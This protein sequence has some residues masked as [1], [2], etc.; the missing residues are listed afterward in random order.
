MGKRLKVD[1]GAVSPSATRFKFV[2][3][4]GHST[5][6]I[7]KGR[8]YKLRRAD[9]GKRITVRVTY[10]RS[11]VETLKVEDLTQREG[12]GTD[13]R[14]RASLARMHDHDEAAHFTWEA[15]HFTQEFW[16]ERY[17]GTDRV[18]SGNPN[19]R[20]VEHASDLTPGAALDVGCGE[21]ADVVWLAGRGW[22]VTGVDVS[23]VAL[24]RAAQ[25]AEERGVAERTSFAQVDLVA[26]DALPGDF[27][28]VSAQFMHLPTSVFERVY[29]AIAR[30]VRPGGALLVVGHHPADAATGLRNERLSHLLF[31]PEQ[32]T[33]VL[34]DAE[35]DF[36][37]P[38]ADPRPPDRTT[39]P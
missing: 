1:L 24:D 14:C 5:I 17:A 36:G 19:P 32:V 27:D 23:Q 35:W 18:W 31:T 12:E 10:A 28:L 9:R 39:N 34:D 8:T 30:A 21:G 22:Q 15:E 3:K 33:A 25:H 16:D 11:G 7:A 6:K 26:G 2:W 20:L 29:V 38:S 13:A 37:S 4:R